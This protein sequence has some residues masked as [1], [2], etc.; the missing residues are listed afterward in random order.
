MSFLLSAQSGD[1]IIGKWLAEEK[2]GITEI[3]WNGNEYLGKIAWLEE[4]IDPET[5]HPY[6]DKNNKDKSRRNQALM[7]LVFMKGF[8]FDPEE[9][10][11]YDGTVYDPKSGNTYSGYI[12]LEDE[13]TLKLRGYIGFSLFGR[14]DIWVRVATSE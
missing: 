11:W 4:P 5:G 3:Y 2:D 6:K 13:D 9:N 10:K 14:T 12:W 1:E 7:G 8:H